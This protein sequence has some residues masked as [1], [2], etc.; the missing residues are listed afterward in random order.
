VGLDVRVRLP[1][2][3]LVRSILGQLEVTGQLAARGDL[4]EPL[5]FGRLDVRP[6][7]KLFLQGREFT[8]RDGA[9]TYSGSWNPELALN[10]DAVIPSVE[11]RDYRVRVSAEGTLEKPG[12]SFSSEPSLSQQEIVSL[13]ATGRLEGRLSDTSAWLVGGQAGA[14]LAGRLTRD[15]AQTFG[16]DEIT[17]RPD[18]IARETDPSARFTFGKKLGRRAG[19][20]YSVG[21]GGPETRFVQ[22]EGR[23]GRHFTLKL[24]RTEAG[25]YA[26]GV[27]SASIGRRAGRRKQ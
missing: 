6:G 2:A 11:F 16:L 8:V 7:G 25:T 21:L 1:R 17:I 23:P 22:L 26:G 24:Q 15:V 10:A 20:V 12:L 5:P 9:M 3:V 19:L 13:I 27:A 4:Q 18:L 14:L